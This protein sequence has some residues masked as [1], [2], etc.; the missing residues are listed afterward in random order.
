MS[1]KKV[2]DATYELLEGEIRKR[3][4]KLVVDAS[5]RALKNLLFAGESVN[6]YGLGIFTLRTRAARMAR[7]PRT[8]EEIQ[9]PPRKHIKFVVSGSVKEELK[10]L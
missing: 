1:R 7:N 3:D 9:V 6:V 5:F 4:V 10:K 8:M 2:T